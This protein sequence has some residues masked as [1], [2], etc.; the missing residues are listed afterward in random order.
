MDQFIEP[1]DLIAE[2]VPVPEG[3]ELVRRDIHPETGELLEILHEHAGCLK[4]SSYIFEEAPAQE[5]EVI[6]MACVPDEDEAAGSSASHVESAAAV[7]PEPKL[8]EGKLY[9]PTCGNH[10]RQS[11]AFI[12]KTCEDWN[13]NPVDVLYHE[14]RP[15]HQ[16]FVREPRTALLTPLG[17]K[18]A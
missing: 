10:G 12:C 2:S 16:L 14:G 1:G 4:E 6:C 11:E 17:R 13:W 5:R 8:K 3:L 18:E 9:C 7:R 15:F